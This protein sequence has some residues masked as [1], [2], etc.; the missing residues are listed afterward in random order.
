[1]LIEFAGLA[2]TTSSSLH[3][4]HIYETWTTVAVGKKF[5]KVLADHHIHWLESLAFP[6]EKGW[7]EGDRYGC[8][9]LLIKLVARQANLMLLNMNQSYDNYLTEEQ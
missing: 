9:E 8:L 6:W 1:M 7:F 3:T 2:V 5:M 4:L